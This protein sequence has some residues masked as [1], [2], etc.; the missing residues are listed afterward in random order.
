MSEKMTIWGVGPKLAVLS[1]AYSIIPILLTS[2]YPELFIVS[3]IPTWV[4]KAAGIILLAAGI[5]L[6]AIS[7]LTIIKGFKEGVPCTQ[8]VYSIVRHPLYSAFIVFIVPGI[9][10]F[11][12]SWILITIPFA[13]YVIFKRLIRKEEDWLE[14]QF[15]ED[16]LR[17][18]SKVHAILPIPR[19]G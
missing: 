14:E 1:F 15:G 4:F 10:M 2:R 9:L 6:W 8:G 7:V 17:Y 16:Y 3:F 11:F 18:K 13:A 12:R 5:P 19:P